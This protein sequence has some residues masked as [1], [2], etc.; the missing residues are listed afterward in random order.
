MTSSCPTTSSSATAATGSARAAPRAATIATATTCC[1]TTTATG[2][3][4][5]SATKRTPSSRTRDSSTTDPTARATTASRHQALQ[6]TVAS[7]TPRRRWLSTALLDHR[8]APST[9]GCMSND[10]ACARP[11]CTGESGSTGTRPC[12][13]G[14]RGSTRCCAPLMNRRSPAPSG[15]SVPSDARRGA[16]WWRLRGRTPDRSSAGRC[17]APDR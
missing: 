1:G 11:M 16:S 2:S 10:N 14:R 12:H 15:T 17:P 13:P 6:S 3:C 4:S 7:P 9:A 8:A 5:S